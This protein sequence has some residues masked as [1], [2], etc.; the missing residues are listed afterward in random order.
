MK[1]I[2]NEE[3]AYTNYIIYAIIIYKFYKRWFYYLII[4]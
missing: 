2:Y 3:E 1:T 4:L